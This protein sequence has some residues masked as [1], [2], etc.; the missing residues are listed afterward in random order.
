MT[1]TATIPA[2]LDVTPPRFVNSTVKLLLRS[3]LHGVLSKS[4]T[5]LYFTGRRSGKAYQVPVQY[6]PDGDDII[7]LS[8]RF[9]TW[10]KNFQDPAPLSLRLRGKTVPAT[11]HAT[12]DDDAVAAMLSRFMAYDPRGAKFY[13]VPI[14]E[15]GQPDMARVREIAPYIVSIRITLD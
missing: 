4:M 7:V 6:M 12:T 3:P 8:K 9:R 14:D 2:K 5:I 13:D 11:A 15:A 1:Q 10:W